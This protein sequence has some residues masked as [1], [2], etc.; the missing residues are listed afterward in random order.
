M[1]AKDTIKSIIGIFVQNNKKNIVD[2]LNNNG[3]FLQLAID[4]NELVNLLY[5]IKKLEPKKFEELMKTF[6]WDLTEPKTNSVEFKAK[7]LEAKS[8]AKLSNPN[9]RT[10]DVDSMTVVEELPNAS[11]SKSFWEETLDVLTGSEES[12]T[13]TVTTSTEANSGGLISKAIIA[14]GVFAS[15]GFIVYFATKNN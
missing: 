9:M 5:S 1:N 12:S 15:L 7:Y 2:F 11:T 3:Y 4:N 8:N 6:K 14:V 13:Q 10:I